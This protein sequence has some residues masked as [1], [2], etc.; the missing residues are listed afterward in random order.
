[1]CA[2][3]AQVVAYPEKHC[4]IVGPTLE[5]L[6]FLMKLK[7]NRENDYLFDILY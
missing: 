5:G 1:M 2:E 4:K 3:T 7:R 6:D